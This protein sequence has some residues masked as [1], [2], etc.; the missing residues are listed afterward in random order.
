MR[1]KRAAQLFFVVIAIMA[2]GYSLRAVDWARCAE[3]IRGIGPW[4]ALIAVPFFCGMNADTIAWRRMLANLGHQVPHQLLL[5]VRLG[6]EAMLLSMA[7]GA[8]LAEGAAPYLLNKQAG[9]PYADG[10]ATSA[11]RKFLL[12]VGQGVYF[13]ISAVVGYEFLTKTSI[14]IIGVSW[15]P[16]LVMAVAIGIL[17]GA[18]AVVLLLLYGRLSE[19]LHRLLTTIPNR[20]LRGWL[21]SLSEGF[22][23]LD[24][25]LSRS[26]D[27]RQ[28][29][30]AL[31]M[32]MFVAV[33]MIES[34][35]TFLILQILGVDIP[36]HH[37]LAFEPAVTLLRNLVF[38][39]P[40]GLG[41]QELGYLAFI[42]AAGVPDPVNVGAA[43]VVLKRTKELFW[44][45]IGYTLLGSLRGNGVNDVPIEE[46]RA[47]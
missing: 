5:R 35:E 32:L 26:V 7:G 19:R 17:G 21:E 28:S 37:V 2:V 13:A 47:A 18:A 4:A 22:S 44:V 29:N 23:K 12:I 14:D 27:A 8:V 15:L 43:F 10:I 3:L 34:L 39:V 24:E 38:V 33:W 36:F 42:R 6:T 1:A 46:H 31:P 9:V 25:Q 16:W 41:V 30:V 11:T 20:R 45:L 40:A